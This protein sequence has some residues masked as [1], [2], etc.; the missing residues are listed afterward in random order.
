MP[1]PRVSPR[2]VV[3]WNRRRK[4]TL[5]R[6]CM[7]LLHI[8]KEGTWLSCFISPVKLKWL[9]KVLQKRLPTG[10]EGS[11]DTRLGASSKKQGVNKGQ[12]ISEPSRDPCHGYLFSQSNWHP[13]MLYFPGSPGSSWAWSS[14]R[15][16]SINLTPKNF[17]LSEQDQSSD[18][19]WQLWGAPSPHLAAHSP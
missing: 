19:I 6:L 9:G 8:C 14:L 11:L 1:R 2:L 5:K 7:Q 12:V 15:S 4:T 3:S 16:S 10:L 13:F 18:Q 17:I